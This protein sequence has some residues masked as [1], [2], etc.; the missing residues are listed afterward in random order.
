M[1]AE[2]NSQNWKVDQN[3]FGK[4][5]QKRLFGHGILKLTVSQEW[6]DR[7][8]WFFACWYKFR[9]AKSCFNNFGIDGTKIEHGHLVHDTLKFAAFN[10]E[11]FNSADFLHDCSDNDYWHWYQTLHL[12]L[13]NGGGPLRSYGS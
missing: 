6:A 3:F 10:N 1:I 7:M 2:K 9:K 13:L 5:G 11:Y 12:R 4:L 8:N